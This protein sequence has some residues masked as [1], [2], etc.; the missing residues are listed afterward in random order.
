M[1]QVFDIDVDNEQTF[2]RIYR[3]NE[4]TY[5]AQPP[6]KRID[7]QGSVEEM[8]AVACP[9]YGFTREPGHRRFIERRPPLS[10]RGLYVVDERVS[11]Q[12]RHFVWRRIAALLLVLGGFVGLWSGLSGLESLRPHPAVALDGVVSTRTGI[13]YRVR[14]GD[15]VWSIATAMDTAGDPRPL[16]STL[17]RELGGTNL[18][19]GEILQLP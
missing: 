15:T 2:V 18:R 11:D 17:V 16:V 1:K 10:P 9:T 7:G 13:T 8:A 6:R 19:P 14:A 5:D 3:G 4:H 12:T